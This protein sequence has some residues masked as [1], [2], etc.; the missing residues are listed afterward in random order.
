MGKDCLPKAARF[1]E[2]LLA[3]YEALDWQ[4]VEI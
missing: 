1:D 3:L 2:W 4:S